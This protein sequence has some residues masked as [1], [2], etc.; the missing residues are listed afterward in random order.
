MNLDTQPALRVKWM[1]GERARD[2]LAALYAQSTGAQTLDGLW[3][4]GD[5]QWWW[6]T[7]PTAD[8]PPVAVAL[9]QDDTPVIV[10]LLVKGRDAWTCELAW[11]RRNDRGSRKVV[12]MMAGAANLYNRMDEWQSEQKPPFSREVWT[13]IQE[14]G[15]A[16]AG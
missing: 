3:E 10:S 4:P 9:D 2:A 11:L 15:A 6:S 7:C 12:A 16:R 5:A 13:F 1:E 14:V 8:W